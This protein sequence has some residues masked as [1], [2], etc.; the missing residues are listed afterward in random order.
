MYYNGRIICIIAKENHIYYVWSLP[1]NQ[2]FLGYLA[3]LCV[4]VVARQVNP[5]FSPDKEKCRYFSAEK[6]VEFHPPN[7]SMHSVFLFSPIY[8]Q[9]KISK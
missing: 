6:K 4:S 3:C 9:L 5:L 8:I 7:Q 2:F 1:S